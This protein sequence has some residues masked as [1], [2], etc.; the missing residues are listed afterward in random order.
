MGVPNDG[1]CIANNKRIRKIPSP[2]TPAAGTSGSV[3]PFDG[4]LSNAGRAHITSHRENMHHAVRRYVTKRIPIL[5]TTYKPQPFFVSRLNIDAVSS[6]I[7]I[8]D[9]NGLLREKKS[10]R[11]RERRYASD[12]DKTEGYL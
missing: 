8:A 5:S 6:E 2:C 10:V 4:L 12:S 7:E 1:V 11:I 9:F 3:P